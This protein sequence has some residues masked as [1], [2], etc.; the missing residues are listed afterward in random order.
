MR[1]V[2][3]PADRR[4]RTGRDGAR[5]SGVAIAA[6]CARS[7]LRDASLLGGAAVPAHAA[8]PRSRRRRP[9]VGRPPARRQPPRSPRNAS[10]AITARLDPASRTLTGDELLTWR[11][12]STNPATHAAVPPLLERLAQHALDV[13]ARAR[14]RRRRR[15]SRDRP[16]VGLGLD[17]RHQPQARSAPSGAPVD[18]TSTPAL[19][20]AGRRQRGRPDGGGGAARP[21]RCAPGETINVA[22]RLVVAGAAHVRAHRRD[23]QLLLPR[24]VVPEDRRARGRRLELPPVPRRDRVLRRLRHL[25]R[26]PDRADGWIVGAT[27][28]ERGRR[29]DARRHDDASLL[30]GGRPRLRL[31]DQPRLRR[32]DASGSSTPAL[33]AVDDAAAAA[34]RARRPG[35]AALRRDARRAQATTASG[36]APIRTATS[37]SSIPAWQSGAGGMEYPTLFTAGTRWLAPRGVAEPGRRHGPRSRPPVLVRHRRDQ[38]VRARVDGRRAQHVLDRARR[39]SRSST[40]NY[41]AKRYFGGFVPWVFDD[42][43]LSRA[44][45]GNRLAGYRDARRSRRASRR[46]RGATGRRPAA[47]SPTTRRRCGCNTLERMLGWAD[48]AADPVHLLRALG[49]SGIPSRRTSSR[50]PTRSAATT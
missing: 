33:P 13:D 30:R 12:T 21:R 47:P 34:A 20:R 23:R 22:D 15:R 37:R 26:A 11:N 36:S 28:V 18:L 16:R 49:S 4:D 27:G 5:R 41:Y 3:I 31:D 19:H 35:R 39:S 46:R 9:R 29:D 50:S 14:A 38:R 24:P 17:R 1:S 25:R 32:A 44:T 7:A 45:D 48:A 6:C 8:P 2:I 42:M 10:Y 40:P 43:P